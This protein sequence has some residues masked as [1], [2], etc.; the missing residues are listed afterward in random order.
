MPLR[1]FDNLEIIDSSIATL[2]RDLTPPFIK[3]FTHASVIDELYRSPWAEPVKETQE[4][5]RSIL[6]YFGIKNSAVKVTFDPILPVPGRVK[7]GISDVFFVDINS[8]Y[9]NQRNVVIAIL[10]HEVAH[11][12]LHKHQIKFEDA[13][14]DEM[15]TDTTAAFLGFGPCIL[16]VAYNRTS[17]T[18]NR[19]STSEFVLGYLSVDEFGYVIAKRNHYFGTAS[20][21]QIEPGL[22]AEGYESGRK[23]AENIRSQRPFAKRDV[24][25]RLF[26]WIKSFFAQN[27][28][29][30]ETPIV[31]KCPH[32]SQKL[33]IPASRKTLQVTC[34]TCRAMQVC[35]S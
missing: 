16:N 1:G 4:I 23:L 9:N 11:I 7:M 35:Y 18:G 19:I 25:D 30:G 26:W 10:A 6:R 21:I 34:S 3:K 24:F 27:Q 14:D 31:F 8:E 33:R 29:N 22:P 13:E 28:G 5:A 32:C 17:R 15:L 20:P 2:F 12:F